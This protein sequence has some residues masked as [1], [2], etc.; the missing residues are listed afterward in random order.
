L[1]VQPLNE[2]PNAGIENCLRMAQ[3][4]TGDLW[5]TTATPKHWVMIEINPNIN[6]ITL[7]VGI[8]HITGE[9]EQPFVT[10]KFQNDGTYT[11]YVHP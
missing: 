1:T 3:M 6:L 8:K 4:F 10:Y 5:K 2:K 9:E 7:S 11:K